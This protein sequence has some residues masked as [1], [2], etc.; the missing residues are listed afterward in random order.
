MSFQRFLKARLLLDY[1]EGHVEQLYR[2]DKDTVKRWQWLNL[3]FNDSRKYRLLL[4]YY[5]NR[6]DSANF[7][8]VFTKALSNG[9][10]S[11][12]LPGSIRNNKSFYNEDFYRRKRQLYLNQLDRTLYAEVLSIGDSDQ[13]YRIKML[14]PGLSEEKLELYGRNYERIDQENF[15]RIRNLTEKHGWLWGVRFDI[16][17]S[18][19]PKPYELHAM[20]SH[21]KRDQIVSLRDIAIGLAE[22]NIISWDEPVVLQFFLSQKHPAFRNNQGRAVFP[23]SSTVVTNGGAI[24]WE[25]SFFELFVLSKVTLQGMKYMRIELFATRKL[26]RAHPKKYKQLLDSLKSLLVDLG[27]NPENIDISYN[28][29]SG[30]KALEQVNF[31]YSVYKHSVGKMN[32]HEPYRLLVL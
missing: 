27:A 8:E 12:L 18:D 5:H 15:R 1:F 6:R 9:F 22:K 24:E 20:I 10:T 13:T 17:E 28:V 29:P 23:L 11:D 2:V 25:K 3:G 14:E 21:F 30:E 7:R 16:K 32:W 26:A 4:K 31:G 19:E